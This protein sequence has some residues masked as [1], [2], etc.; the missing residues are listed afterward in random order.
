MLAAFSSPAAR[1]E[2]GSGARI[3]SGDG[4]VELWTDGEDASIDVLSGEIALVTASGARHTVVALERFHLPEAFSEPIPVGDLESLLG[5]LSWFA[6]GESGGPA[7]KLAG[8][9]AAR[10]L[11]ESEGTGRAAAARHLSAAAAGWA[12]GL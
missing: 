3:E 9:I 10:A 6:A 7:R 12:G 1:V 2:L 4:L 11:Q 5:R 8:E